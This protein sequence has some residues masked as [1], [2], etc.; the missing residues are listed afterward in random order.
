MRL[1]VELKLFLA[2]IE[3]FLAGNLQF[4]GQDVDTNGLGISG[5]RGGVLALG[6]VASTASATATPAAPALLAAFGGGQRF[7]LLW[8][9]FGALHFLGP[10]RRY[11]QK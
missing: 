7:S 5:L 3:Q 11:G 2:D 10:G 4:L 1:D 6:L 8:G 9:S